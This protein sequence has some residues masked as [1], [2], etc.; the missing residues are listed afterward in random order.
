MNCSAKRRRENLLKTAMKTLQHSQIQPLEFCRECRHVLIGAET[1]RDETG[2]CHECEDSLCDA[3]GNSFV[4]FPIKGLPAQLCPDCYDHWVEWNDPDLV[5]GAS[6]NGIPA[7]LQ[8]S[9]SMQENTEY[10]KT[11]AYAVLHIGIVADQSGELQRCL[12]C[13]GLGRNEKPVNHSEVCPVLLAEAVLTR[14]ER[15]QMR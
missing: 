8:A 7:L 6:L 11:L 12:F 15:E 4:E 13:Y 10:L 9:R 3:C 2:L 5:I 1:Y 14:P